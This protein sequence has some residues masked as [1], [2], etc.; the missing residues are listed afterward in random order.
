[1]ASSPSMPEK[2]ALGKAGMQA[3]QVCLTGSVTMALCSLAG[4]SPCACQAPGQHQATCSQVG[5]GRTGLIWGADLCRLDVLQ[6]N[7]P[8]PFPLFPFPYLLPFF[9]SLIPFLLPPTLSLPLSSPPFALNFFSPFSFHLHLS[10]FFLMLLLFPILSSLPI[11]F[12]FSSFFPS[13]LPQ[14]FLF[15]FHFHFSFPLCFH[16]PLIFL[17]PFSTPSVLL[18]P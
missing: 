8:F 10:P 9:L 12:L 17:F 3:P 15:S 11:V 4:R 1:M 18:L 5:L 6:A 7:L 14:D 13:P 16:L 2:A